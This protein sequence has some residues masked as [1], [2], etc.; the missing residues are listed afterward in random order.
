MVHASAA[1]DPAEVGTL[2]QA[3]ARV[4]ER[5]ERAAVRAGRDPAAITLV[6]VSKTVS[7]DRLRAAVAAGL[8]RLG[9]NRVQEGEAKA[10][11]VP[12][13]QWELVGPLQSNKARR[14]LTTFDRI[15]TVDSVELARRLDRLV[16]ET[17]PGARYPILLQVNVD[18]DPAKAGFQP[19]AIEGALGDLLALPNLLVEGLMTVGR[20]TTSPADARD[21]FR[22]LHGLADRLRAMA[23]GLG[24]TLSMGMSDDFELAIE[25]GAT[26]VRVGRALFGERTHQHPGVD[27][28]H[29]H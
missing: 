10:P 3:R 22:N 11:A 21:T 9:E 5:I 29:D 1:V 23:P 28:P 8:D 16:P 4:L 2:T 17:R 25:E 18:R 14:A 6:A 27:G 26:V 15:Q 24:D 13:A 20:F 7:P 12:G 19:D